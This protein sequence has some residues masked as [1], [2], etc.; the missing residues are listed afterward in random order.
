MSEWSFN[1]SIS[2]QY[3]GFGCSIIK[4]GDKVIFTDPAMSIQSRSRTIFKKLKIDSIEIKSQNLDLK[5]L[6]MILVGHAHHDHLMDLPYLF[7]SG[8]LPDSFMLIGN[9]SMRN[10][11]L[12]NPLS[13]KVILPEQEANER[14][15]PKWIFNSERSIRVLPIRARHSC[16]HLFKG[17]AKKYKKAFPKR[18]CK[19]RS[20]N[21]Y[22]FFIDFL[23]VNG[24]VDKRIFFQSSK[25][26]TVDLSD[27]TKILNQKKIDL[28]LIATRGLTIKEFDELDE[29]LQ[30]D[31]Y[32]ALH[33]EKFF[34]KERNVPAKSKKHELLKNYFDKR[35]DKAIHFIPF[36][37]IK[38]FE[39][40]D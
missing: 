7:D 33:W 32:V 31:S 29:K 12:S 36:G 38:K 24:E 5:G 30:V 34:S 23:S 20:G 11:L 21:T 13:E 14:N 28:A 40:M 16:P 37:S 39:M 35:G 22:C 25:D 1:D 10:I 26:S 19:W 15:S 6:S 2:I 17:T 18:A 3:F 4:Y 8:V 9:E 27:F